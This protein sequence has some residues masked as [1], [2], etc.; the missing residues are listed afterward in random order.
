VDGQLDARDTVGEAVVPG[1]IGRETERDRVLRSLEHGRFDGVLL[2]G[3]TGVGRTHLLRRC[4]NDLRARGWATLTVTGSAAD[5]AAALAPFAPVLN[6]TDAEDAVTR[7]SA[8]VETVSELATGP[9]GVLAVDDVH[10]LDRTSAAALQ[11]L[12]DTSEVRLLM[13][14][15]T[16]A[17]LPDPVQRLRTSARTDLVELA[18]LTRPHIEHIIDEFLDGPVATMTRAAFWQLSKGSPLVLHEALQGARDEDLLE[19]QRGVWFHTAP[20]TRS[21]RIVD[22]A[23][24]E[25]APLDDAERRA[26]EVVAMG[27]PLELGFLEQLAPLDAVTRL[28]ERGDIAIE[29]SGDRITV[30]ARHDWIRDVLVESLGRARRRRIARDLARTL[31]RTELRRHH[32]LPRAVAW[33]IEAGARVSNSDLIEAARRCRVDQHAQRLVIALRAARSIGDCESYLLAGEAHAAAGEHAAAEEA[34]EIADELARHDAERASVAMARAQHLL[35]GRHDPD[36]ALDTVTTAAQRCGDPKLVDRL[37]ALEATFLSFAGQLGRSKQ[38]ADRLLT[39]PDTDAQAVVSVLTVSTFVET[40]LGEPRAA[41]QGI[42]RGRA[43]LAQHASHLPWAPT[44]LGINEAYALLALGDAIGGDD[45]CRQG[46]QAALA[47]DEGPLA[48]AWGTVRASILIERGVVHETR[49]LATEVVR[50]LEDGDP[51]GVLP[52]AIALGALARAFAGDV[53]GAHTD[54]EVLDAQSSTGHRFMIWRGRAATWIA[55]TEGDLARAHKLAIETGRWGESHEQLHWSASAYHDLVRLG[56]AES[57]IGPLERV[58]A[59]LDS[60]V[61]AIMVEH[62]QALLDGQPDDLL[63]LTDR[64]DACGLTLHAAEAAGQAATLRQQAGRAQAAARARTRMDALLQRCP[65]ARTPM[66]AAPPPILTPRELQVAR[67]ANN[68]HS[69]AQ[70]AERLSITVRTVDNHLYRVYSKLGIGGRRGLRA[71]M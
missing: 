71:I 36:L 52:G 19:R 42:G 33:E 14:A 13:T 20:L 29:A 37:R 15:P 4:A 35:L 56:G 69:S 5:P 27:Q 31:R 21:S 1:P 8:V 26:L 60:P 48:G 25:L 47:G 46:Y 66:I 58:A 67:L 57:A 34:F 24:R 2:T 65:G 68:G 32:D 28:E 59:A 62:A 9:R 49:D 54:L 7:L 3:P 22:L 38:V 41:L 64:F 45:V 63:S 30:Q 39:W 44:Q 53:R 6:A 10:L 51:L 16:H 23:L 61:G 17:T 11:L 50:L 12:A 18:P 43:L 70:I 40:L 55:A